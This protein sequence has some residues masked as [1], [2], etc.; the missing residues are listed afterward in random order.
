MLKKIL[1]CI[2]LLFA[3]DVTSVSAMQKINHAEKPENCIEHPSSPSLSPFT[4]WERN[5]IVTTCNTK[6][7]HTCLNLGNYLNYYDCCIPVPYFEDLRPWGV[8]YYH[9]WMTDNNI[10]EVITAHN[11]VFRY[12][13]MDTLEISHTLSPHNLFRRLLQPFV[14]IVQVAGNVTRRIDP[15]GIIYEFDPY[16]IV[17]WEHFPWDRYLVNTFAFGDGFSYAT[18]LPAREVKDSSTDS[19]KRFLN[20]LLLEVT[21]ALPTHPEWELVVRVHHRCGAWGAF[22]AGNLSSNAVGLGVRYLFN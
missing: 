14:C 4:Q 13:T 7:S 22:G 3:L 12:G 1:L 11:L 2:T 16:L 17:R 6:K 10:S 9:S 18:G 15:N 8:M 5:F 21:F 19:P 20:F